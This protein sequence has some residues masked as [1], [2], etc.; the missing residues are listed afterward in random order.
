MVFSTLKDMRL[1]FNKL[2]MKSNNMTTAS[3]MYVMSPFTKSLVIFSAEHAV[4]SAE[5]NKY[6]QETVNHEK[7][8]KSFKEDIEAEIKKQ[9]GYQQQLEQA[10]RGY[11]NTASQ[12]STD[13]RAFTGTP[14]YGTVAR[15][16]PAGA[17]TGAQKRFLDYSAGQ[18]RPR[19]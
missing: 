17:I 8:L 15:N 6:L 4:S 5:L 1:K 11:S 12:L 13:G 16:G 3:K 19:G 18:P 14:P 2:T 9:E 10:G 7:Q